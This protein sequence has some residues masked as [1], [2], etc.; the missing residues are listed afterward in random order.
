MREQFDLVLNR[1]SAFNWSEVARVLALSGTFLTQQVH[2][3]WAEDLL[4]EFGPA[5]QWP[6]ATPGKYVPRLQVPGL[7]H[8]QRP[9]VDR[10]FLVHR[11]PADH[12]PAATGA[13]CSTTSASM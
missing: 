12:A 2:G 8:H 5:P 7:P 11:L 4:A 9:G 13:C 3:R 10:S 1:H 6:G